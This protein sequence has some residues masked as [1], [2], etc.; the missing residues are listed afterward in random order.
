MENF[1]D[2]VCR[3]LG[4]S[5]IW[6][7]P[8]YAA[9]ADVALLADPDLLFEGPASEIIKDQRKIKVARIHI[10]AGGKARTLYLKRYNAFSWRYRL[11]SLITPSGASRSLAGAGILMSAGF[12]TG[13]PIAAVECRSWGML[14]KSFY[15]SEE[16][17]GSKTADVYWREALALL[18]GREGFLRRRK[19]LVSLAKLFRS[20]HRLSIY[21]N[22]LKDA[23][24]LVCSGNSHGDE[25][26]YLLDLEG[27]RRYRYLNRRRQFKNLVQLNRTMG[28][29]LRR[30]DKLRWLKGYLGDIFMDRGER[31]KWIKKV[32]EESVRRDRRSLRKG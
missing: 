9:P 27:I 21:H 13:Q 1:P 29:F 15:I 25:S 14:T 31:R 22:D 8:E 11:V 3:K 7:A 24:I 6:V 5:S 32:L 2:F 12:R 28:R 19:F 26:F 20:L 17:V 16:I 10:I 23:N 4:D 30:T 18:S